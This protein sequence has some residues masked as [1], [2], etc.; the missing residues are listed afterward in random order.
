MV[1][2]MKDETAGV[3]VKEF[4]GLKPKTNSFL[5]DDICEHK[6]EKGANKMLLQQYVIMNIKMFCWIINV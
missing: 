2:R 3:A 1:S 5:V 4:V 6:K